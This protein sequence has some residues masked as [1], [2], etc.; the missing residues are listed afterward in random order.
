MKLCPFDE[1][2]PAELEVVRS[3]ELGAR[4][5]GEIEAIL[6]SDAISGPFTPISADSISCTP[7]A[8]SASSLLEAV[9]RNT[10]VG[11]VT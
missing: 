9:M 7:M 4:F 2:D 10:G 6:P 1:E 11:T 5:G 8:V 3:R